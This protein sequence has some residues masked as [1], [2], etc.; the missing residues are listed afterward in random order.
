MMSSCGPD[1]LF[2]SWSVHRFKLV[3]KLLPATAPPAPSPP[4]GPSWG[5]P[6]APGGVPCRRGHVGAAEPSGAHP[7]GASG[8]SHAQPLPW[9][10]DQGAWGWGWRCVAGPQA[11]PCLAHSRHQGSRA[12]LASDHGKGPH[13]LKHQG[14]AQCCLRPSLLCPSYPCHCPSPYSCLQTCSMDS[15]M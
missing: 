7:N 9:Q 12:I 4:P 2:G 15:A 11:A 3:H 6:C 14:D 5:G 1:F 13:R 8:P 10:W